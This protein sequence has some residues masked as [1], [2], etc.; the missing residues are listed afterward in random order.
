MPVPVAGIAVTGVGA[1]AGVAY[2]FR[3]KLKSLFSKAKVTSKVVVPESTPVVPKPST[4]DAPKVIVPPPPAPPQ[5]TPPIPVPPPK[6]AESG[7]MWAI[8]LSNLNARKS[9]GTAA[10]LVSPNDIKKD[11]MVEILDWNAGSKDGYD[12]AKVVTPG[13]AIGYSAKKWLQPTDGRT[14]PTV[15]TPT[16]EERK[17]YTQEGYRPYLAVEEYASGTNTANPYSPVPAVLAGET[18]FGADAQNDALTAAKRLYAFLTGKMEDGD[19][20][21]LIRAFQKAHNKNRK[22][23]RIGV[24]L[25]E[26]GVYTPGTSAALT[27]YTGAPVAADPTSR[28]RE[29]SLG[30]VLT[31][32]TLSDVS[33]AGSAKLAQFNLKTYLSHFGAKYDDP[34]FVL[35]VREFQ[36]ASNTDPVWPGPSYRVRP[37]PKRLLPKLEVNG[38]LDTHTVKAL[39][40]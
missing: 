16:Y 22:M 2:L 36:N 20:T 30:E 17:E 28:A 4:P 32:K 13:G 19:Q 7:R 9:I 34:N 35:L 3:D 1:A 33:N 12:W 39:N 40:V 10:P 8:A 11:M 31:T 37:A 6:P 23:L 29:A 27:Q 14:A 24:K 38:S 15:W 5:V 26:S 25:T 21:S 18:F